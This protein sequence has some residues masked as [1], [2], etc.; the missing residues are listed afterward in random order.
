VAAPETGAFYFDTHGSDFNTVLN[1]YTG[2]AVDSLTRIAEK[3]NGSNSLVAFRAEAGT[4]YYIAVYGWQPGNI[5]L[6]WRKA[7]SPANDIFANAIV[8]TGVSGQTTGTNIEATKEPGEPNHIDE[9]YSRGGGYSVWYSWTAPETDIFYFDTLGSSFKVL[10]V[11]TGSA[12]DSLIR[13]TD[14]IFHAKAGTRYYIAADSRWSHELGDIVLN[15]NKVI[16]RTAGNF[17]M[18]L[19][20]RAFAAG[21][22][23]GGSG[24]SVLA[25]GPGGVSDCRGKAA[26]INFET[27]WYYTKSLL[28][29]YIN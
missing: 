22:R 12:V 14:S 24:C 25:F 6:N 13:V 11:Y 20:G 4:R 17:K 7:N 8:L 27:E 15:W 21:A 2:S 9:D 10:A 16:P 29:L 5:V 19:R 3:Y 1:V 18:D 28:K 23:I 26:F